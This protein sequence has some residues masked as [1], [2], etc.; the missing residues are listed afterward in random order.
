MMLSLVVAAAG[1]GWFQADVRPTETELRR[2][3][4]I[5]MGP[6]TI[7]SAIDDGEE[8]G[9]RL[10]R[11]RLVKG[12]RV[13][14]NERTITYTVPDT[15]VKRVVGF[16]INPAKLPREIDLVTSDERVMPGVYKIEGDEL[17]V[18]FSE[19]H[20]P[21]RPTDFES[22]AGSSRMLLR[23]AH[24]S[25]DAATVAP[26][27]LVEAVEIKN[28]VP[29]PAEPVA[30]GRIRATAEEIAR[31]RNL[32]AGSWDIVSIRDDGELLGAE[33]I[34][35]KIA[36]DGRVRIGS[37]G[38]SVTSPISE[39]RRLWAYR[40][41]PATTPKEIDLITEHDSILKGIYMFD[42]DRLIVCSAKEEE[43]ARPSTFE[44]PTGSRHVLYTFR[45]ARTE[46]VPVATS[47]PAPAP[48]PAPEP[49]P[50]REPEPTPAELKAMREE[51]IREMLVGSWT[52]TDS[53]GTLVMVVRSDG[54]FSSTR[55]VA[56]PR[57]FQPASV[58]SGGSWSYAAGV[59]SAR[60]SSTTDPNMLGYSYVNRLQSI[61]P[62]SLVMGGGV[63][64]LK[65][66]RKL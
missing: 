33:L 52:I 53:K 29:V 41:D 57:L 62:T 27:E 58:S 32:M 19:G 63:G 46:A 66:Y 17:V 65:T 34:R 60:I 31:D 24:A 20:T 45:L 6:W 1:I 26:E 9:L 13:L 56:R 37:R 28:D 11:D 25:G 35:R 3:R 43:Q 38:V 14:I 7:A 48:A 55:T 64:P 16:K 30:L 2:A 23:F 21:V 4:Q 15:G 44:A 39:T 8:I 59:F 10:I 61:S 12:G 5:L 40:I 42:Q 22:L 49:K 36:E 50:V 47:T 54:S 51:Q 18:C